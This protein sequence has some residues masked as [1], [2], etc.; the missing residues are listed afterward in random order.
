VK[1]VDGAPGGRSRGG[2][3]IVGIGIASKGTD[4]GSKYGVIAGTPLPKGAIDM[5][6]PAWRERVLE[7]KRCTHSALERGARIRTCVCLD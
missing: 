6:L 5:S 3:S 4:V 1:E 2:R 7:V